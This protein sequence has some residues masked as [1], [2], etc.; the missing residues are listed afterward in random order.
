MKIRKYYLYISTMLVAILLASYGIVMS[1]KA[2]QSKRDLDG[3]Y[4]RAYYDLTMYMSNVESLLA[5]TMIVSHPDNTSETLEQIWKQAD[6]AQEN[7]S[8]LPA[9]QNVFSKTSKFLNQLSNLADSAKEYLI[10][11]GDIPE[12]YRNELGKMHEYSMVLSQ[13]LQD[14]ESLV[15][16]GSNFWDNFEN[17]D[18][19][20][21][22]N[23]LLG[24]L[25][26]DLKDMPEIVYDGQYSDH[27]QLAEPKGLQ[28]EQ[29]S[30][31]Q[32]IEIM[33]SILEQT[34]ASPKNVIVSYEIEG[35]IPAY[36]IEITMID[37]SK[38]TANIS[39]QGGSLIWYL[40]NKESTDD[41]N[42]TMAS[43]MSY[44]ADFLKSIGYEDMVPT[45]GETVYNSTTGNVITINYCYQQ[46]GVSIYPDLVRLRIDGT[47]GTIIGVEANGYLNC[48]TTR[49]ID[50]P[51]LS[52]EDANKYIT[53][54]AT[55][56]STTLCII[57]TDFGTEIL[58]YELNIKYKDKVYL[59]YINCNTGKEENIVIKE[60]N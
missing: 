42:V 54:D 11:T 3:Q 34:G 38:A 26:R 18:N 17:E 24:N 41:V 49:T 51:I 25:D 46:D 50:S 13:D 27:L 15:S 20:G 21:N 55:I 8:V 56:N 37:G 9:G 10:A 60:N 30:G 33:K 39:K 52:I 6:L 40:W 14:L 57:P 23:N 59:V 53:E 5:E 7:L 16:Q 28:G 29:I 32:A 1:D 22:D 2:E 19:A 44:G 47:D 31:D 35:K 43:A 36:S 4:D 45:H 58:T 48:H 12:S